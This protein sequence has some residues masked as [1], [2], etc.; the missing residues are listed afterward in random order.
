MIVP[1]GK[2]TKEELLSSWEEVHGVLSPELRGVFLKR[3]EVDLIIRY[4]A[5]AIRSARHV[6]PRLAII[7]ADLKSKWAINGGDAGKR[8]NRAQ[9]RR[10]EPGTGAKRRDLAAEGHILPL[11]DDPGASRKKGSPGYRTGEE[12]EL[13]HIAQ[14]YKWF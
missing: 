5:H 2:M 9:R 10:P 3:R 14:K 1:L 8:S 6:S 4:P 7:L 12:A 11:P 13:R